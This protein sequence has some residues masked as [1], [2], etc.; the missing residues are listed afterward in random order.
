MR[1]YADIASSRLYEPAYEIKFSI[2]NTGKV[3]GSEVSQRYRGFSS[4][5][6]EPPK[7]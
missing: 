4:E 2:S 5:A 3:N 6:E 7:I 1:T